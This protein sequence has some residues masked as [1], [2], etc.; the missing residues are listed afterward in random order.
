MGDKEVMNIRL[1]EENFYYNPSWSPDSKKILYNDKHL[2]LYYVDIQ[3]K[4][5]CIDRPRSF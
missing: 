2:K 4:K 5:A 3:E 1:D